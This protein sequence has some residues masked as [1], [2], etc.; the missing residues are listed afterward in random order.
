MADSVRAIHQTQH[1]PLLAQRSKAFKWKPNA[2]HADYGVEYRDLDLPST[3]LNLVD[4]GSERGD[5]PV[6]LDRER[7]R[8][9]R[10]LRGCCLGNIIDSFLARAINACGVQD[11]LILLEDQTPK[12]GVHAGGGVGDEDYFIDWG[13]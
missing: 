6:I 3:F 11:I 10:R 5:E 8:D 9:L 12:N 4:L 7:V 13:V 1:A 2:W